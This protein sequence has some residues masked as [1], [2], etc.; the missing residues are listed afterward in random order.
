MQVWKEIKEYDRQRELS[1]LRRIHG[2]MSEESRF[3]IVRYGLNLSYFVLYKIFFPSSRMVT[4]RPRPAAAGKAHPYSLKDFKEIGGKPENTSGVMGKVCTV[5]ASFSADGKI[6]ERV[7]FAAREYAKVSD[8]ILIVGD[9]DLKDASGISEIEPYVNCV[10]YKRHGQ[11]DSGSWSRGIWY[12]RKKGLLDDFDYLVLANDSSYGPV[13]PLAEMYAEMDAK[14]TDFW[15]VTDNVDIRKHIQSYF[16][17]FRKKVFTDDIFLAYYSNLPKKLSFEDAVAFETHITSA[18][19]DKFTYSVLLEGYSENIRGVYTG[20]HNPTIWSADLMRSGSPFLKVKA[21]NGGFGADGAQSPLDALDYVKGINPQLS[22]IIDDDLGDRFLSYD[23]HE[24]RCLPD[25]IGYMLKDVSVVSFD[26]FDTLLMRPFMSPPDLFSYM[27]QK[28]GL[29]GFRLK[30]EQAEREARKLYP[31]GEVTL[32]EIYASAEESIRPYKDLELETELELIMPHPNGKK[33]YEQARAAGRKVVCTSDTYF[34]GET[35]RKMLDKCG[36][37]DFDAYFLS[38]ERRDN[39]GGDIFNIVIEEMGC[40]PKDI[41]HIGDNP[42]ADYTC[43]INHGLRALGIWRAVDLF[44]QMPT[45]DKFLRFNTKNNL[46]STTIYIAQIARYRMAVDKSVSAMFDIGYCLAGPIV[47]SY[48]G[49]IRDQVRYHGIDRL[50]FASRDGCV[51]NG[52]FNRFFAAGTGARGEYVYLSRYV[53][54]NSMLDFMGEASYLELLLEAASEDLEG[55][56]VS[57]DYLSNLAVFE[58]HRTELERWSEGRR[59]NFIRHLESCADGASRIAVVDMF[60][61]KMSAYHFAKDALGDSVVLAI[62]AGLIAPNR[63]VPNVS[64]MD[65]PVTGLMDEITLMEELITSP[66][67]P[68]MYIGRDLKP[69]FGSDDLRS[70]D[71]VKEILSGAEAFVEDYVGAFGVDSRPSMMSMDVCLSLLR[72]YMRYAS[73]A[74]ILILR[75]MKHSADAKGT[76]EPISIADMVERIRNRSAEEEILVNPL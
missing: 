32:D 15:G 29:Y 55:I 17:A 44:I 75:S 41:L 23:S 9:Y 60:T 74:D 16:I 14:G 52:L 24:Y 4:E 61:S 40:D 49:Y 28:Y 43:P 53:G 57:E 36:F 19:S 46:L 56:S 38:C 33:Y 42:M 65:A 72:H 12:L 35:I 26:I 11:Y 59:S 66:E 21:L 7:V 64:F 30:R 69:V 6:P 70:G 51:L 2:A 71:D 1:I 34:S 31:N 50:F 58:G 22:R 3:P 45:N 54:I 39:K 25:S 20:N 8:Y 18:L 37:G 5:L 68:V 48:L 63:S 67:P 27:E 10:C 76:K 47:C 73:D 13:S 62:N